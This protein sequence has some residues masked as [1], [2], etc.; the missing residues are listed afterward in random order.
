MKKRNSCLCRFFAAVLGIGPVVWGSPST[1]VVTRTGDSGAGS[2]RQAITDANN[3]SGADTVVFNIPN[4]DSGYNPS[5]GVWTIQPV[6]ALPAIVDDGTLIDGATQALNQGDNNPLGPEIEINGNNAVTEGINIEGSADNTIRGLAINR[7]INSGISII[8]FGSDRNTVCGNYI[9]TDP[10]G[11]TGFS[12][13]PTGVVVRDGKSNTIGGASSEMRNIVSGN[14]TGVSIASDRNQ[15]VGN[16]I[17]TDRSGTISIGNSLRGIIIMGAFNIVGGSNAEER[18]VI[19]ANS[20]GVAISGMNARKNV[21]AGNFIGLEAF[22]SV[23]LKNGRGIEI[24]YGAAENTVGGTTAGAGNVISGSNESGILLEETSGNSIFGNLIGTDATGTVALGNHVGISIRSDAKRNFIGGPVEGEGN[25]I[26]GNS[27]KGIQIFRAGADSNVVQ[28]NFIGTDIMG[29]VSI[30]N[31]DGV[32]INGSARFNRIGG[33]SEGEGNLI[34]GNSEYG[35]WITS[36]AEK[37]VLCGNRI[38]CDAG[39]EKAL[40][41]GSGGIYIDVGARNNVTGP[42]NI[43][44]FNKGFGIVVSSDT[45]SGNTITQNSISGNQGGGIMLEDG[46][47]NGV[48]APVI[49]GS[50]PLQGTALANSTVEIFSDSADQGRMYE[51]SVIAGASGNWLWTGSAHGPNVTATATDAE[52]NTSEFSAPVQVTAIAEKANAVLEAFSLAQNF[53]NPFNPVTTI[54]FR[55][56]EACRVTLKVYD[57]L[58]KEVAVLANGRFEAGNHTVMF[59]A[60]GL[61]S[62]IYMYRIHMGDF[63]AARKMSMFK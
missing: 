4:T 13:T 47:N 32:I 12:N 61:P 21:V 7:F 20:Y 28:G 15:I 6:S 31:G 23:I 16:Y 39:G 62:G 24:L 53:P 40:A 5:A 42:G 54:P 8:G 37:N 52:G 48:E 18:N 36:S 35:I 27:D 45:T 25:L 49:V 34:S 22:G 33:S 59:D 1:F 10:A 30:P 17:G 58:G 9:G 14:R 63:K 38:G 19:S 50:L 60:S 41:N 26:S 29:T 44:R 56:K 2:L 51:G 43:V 11:S 46:A 3:H 57:I 55:V